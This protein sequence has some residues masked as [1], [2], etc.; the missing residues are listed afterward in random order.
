[1]PEGEAERLT[2]D[3][4]HAGGT[5]LG[6]PQAWNILK[7]R[8]FTTERPKPVGS[9]SAMLFAKPYP[10]EL[11][12][13]TFQVHWNKVLSM[14]TDTGLNP[15]EETPAAQQLRQNYWGV[16]ANPPVGSAYHGAAAEARN[17]T[18]Q[19]CTTIAH[20]EAFLEAMI[21]AV[22]TQVQASGKRPKQATGVGRQ[23]HANYGGLTYDVY[24]HQECVQV[25]PEEWALM[26]Q[27]VQACGAFVPPPGFQ[28]PGS[29]KPFGGANATGKRKC[30]RCA[31]QSDGSPTITFSCPQDS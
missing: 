30:C 1:M 5:V 7:T 23:F 29:T 27:E 17:A 21:R 15:S 31:L 8:W 28:A 20:R 13:E 25:T 26:D 9:I 19:E 3:C 22:D 11:S 16:L 18:S 24:V 4:V 10:Q 6:A 2:R 12:V 14:A